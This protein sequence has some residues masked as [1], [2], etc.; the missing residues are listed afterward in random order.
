MIGTTLSGNLSDKLP[1]AAR[2][3]S[4]T[5][6]PRTATGAEA[7]QRAGN[8]E[9]ASATAAS[10]SSAT[11]A[12][13][14]FKAQQNV[15][16]VQSSVSVSLSSGNEPL[17]LMLKSAIQGINEALAPTLGPDA[18]QNAMSQDNSPQAT[19]DRI[20]S[21]STGFF[22]AY[23]KQNPDKDPETLV[24][25]FV[26]TIRSGFERGFNEASDI[27][28]GLNALGDDIKGSIDQTYA[29]VQKGYDDFIASK[30]K[31]LTGGGDAGSNTTA[32]AGKAA[33]SKSSA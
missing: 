23:A 17:A 9:Q 27:L 6:P 10:K 16:I 30:T 14:Q 19:A 18:I 33:V 5:T 20:L 8:S 1:L 7:S 32:D 29:L 26:A 2:T 22:E 24:K 12:L 3:S 25:D 13:A 21:L 4:A 11:A 31:E 28:K 15:Q